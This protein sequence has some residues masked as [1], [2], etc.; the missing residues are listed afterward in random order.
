MVIGNGQS[1]QLIITLGFIFMPKKYILFL[2]TNYIWGGSEVLWIE[3]ARQL[4]KEGYV[5]RAGLQY[6]YELVKR[7]I[8][9]PRQ[10]IDLRNR[11]QPLSLTQRVAAK[12]KLATYTQKDSL[13]ESFKQ[14]KPDL[15]IISQGNNIDGAHFMRDCTR[16]GIPFITITHLV[17]E[18]FWPSLD[19]D[20]ADELRTVYQQARC[21]YFVSANTLRL[22]EKL[23][24][25][26]LSNGKVV[27]NPFTKV[28]PPGM[29]FPLVENNSYK[30]ALIGRLETFHK[31]YDLLID[32][33]KSEKWRTRPVHFSLFGKG[34]H[35]RLIQRMIEQHGITNFT[36]HPHIDDIS[37]IWKTH[38]L[39]LMPSRIEGQSLTLI[40][41]MRF[42]RA[43]VVTNVGGT[44][45]LIEEGVNGFIADY[46]NAECIDAAM[47]R[48]W[49]QRATWEQLGL[50][51]GNAIAQK[52][53]ADALSAF[54]RQIISLL[55]G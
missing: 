31:G 33:I 28:I 43:A 3:S 36:L 44:A 23:L 25:E 49:Q 39:L 4:D 11:L 45:E 10:Y 6:D 1:H 42:G 35:L 30:V 13:H 18:G 34:P 54:N 14:R 37:V 47:E 22:H 46:P 55:A 27:Y 15:V 17:T 53:P 52:H 41:A 38:H 32:V 20:L 16:F 29:S 7:F 5:V 50:N 24:G 9:Q 2:S 19:D 48:A 51:A 12:L 40:E 21:N 8:K 26:K